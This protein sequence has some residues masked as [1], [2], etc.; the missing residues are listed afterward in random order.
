V[1]GKL[2][3]GA[4]DALGEALD[5]AQVRRIEGENAIR[6]PQFSLFYDDSF[7]LI[8]TRLGHFLCSCLGYTDDL[9]LLFEQL[10]LN[11]MD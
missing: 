10:G 1:S 6:L 3:S 11:F 8:I 7:C 9:S 2:A 4:P 5:F